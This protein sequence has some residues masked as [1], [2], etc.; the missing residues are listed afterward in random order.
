MIVSVHLAEVGRPTALRL[1]R[2]KLDPAEV[3]GLR[4]AVMTT[5]APLGGHLPPRPNLGDVGLIAA[6]EEESA[7]EEFL[8][9]HRL[10]K[11]LAHGWRVRLRPTRIYGA[12]P[13]V[14]DLLAGGEEAMEEGEPAAVLTIGRL[15]LT[16]TIRFLKASAKAEELAVRNPALLASTGLARPPGLVGTF[17]LW[18]SVPAMREYVE[19]AVGPGH[20]AA[21]RAHAARPF[22]HSSAFVRFRPYGAEGLWEGRNPLAA[23]APEAPPE[24]PRGGVTARAM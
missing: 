19:G 12:W 6:W 8:T 2:T 5:T 14:P 21:I 18:R 13:Q 7:V 3:R 23:T 22:H 4:Y 24:T 10:A 16:Q 1:L 15:R 11:R 20:R 17:S 9:A